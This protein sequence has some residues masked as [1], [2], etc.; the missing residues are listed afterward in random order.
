L[1]SINELKRL[2]VIQQ[3]E[4]QIFEADRTVNGKF[5]N[6]KPK[7]NIIQIFTHSAL[8]IDNNSFT[9]HCQNIFCWNFFLSQQKFREMEKNIFFSEAIVVDILSTYLNLN[10]EKL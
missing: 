3:R 1:K 9:F 2:I 8:K 10:D 4:R 6:N 7:F 5:N